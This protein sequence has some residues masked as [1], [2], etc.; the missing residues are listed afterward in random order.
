[1]NTLLRACVIAFSAAAFGL[2]AGAAEFKQMRLSDGTEIEYAL[3]LPAGFQND[4]HY[5]A[6]LAFPGGRQT[7]ESVK[8]GLSRY[9]ELAVEGLNALG[10]GHGTSVMRRE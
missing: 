3:V 2:P 10:R 5:P 6:L 8:G 1:M 4:K 9:W 7:L